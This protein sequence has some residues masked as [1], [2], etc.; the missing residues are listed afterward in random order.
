M[1]K[2]RILFVSLSSTLN[3]VFCDFVKNKI[4]IKIQNTQYIILNILF[5]YNHD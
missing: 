4:T 5:Q 1:N 3:V 2:T